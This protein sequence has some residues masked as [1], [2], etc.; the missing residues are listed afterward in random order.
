[1]GSAASIVS[2]A[3]FTSVDSSA[4]PSVAAASAG[5]PAVV[6][7]PGASPFYAS[8]SRHNQR[9][10]NDISRTPH[11]HS[12]SL[13][14]PRSPPPLPPPDSFAT[15]DAG[16][17]RLAEM[18]DV[19]QS[20]EARVHA[21]CA[22][23]RAQDGTDEPLVRIENEFSRAVARQIVQTRAALQ[24]R[25]W[26]WLDTLTRRYLNNEALS[27][28]EAGLAARTLPK[29]NA[30]YAA[31]RS[32]TPTDFDWT[33]ARTP[34]PRA[35]MC[36][37]DTVDYATS[38]GL[39]PSSVAI[40]N[41]VGCDDDVED[42]ASRW[43]SLRSRCFA[44]LGTKSERTPGIDLVSKVLYC[45]VEVM[46]C[47]V[48]VVLASLPAYYLVDLRDEFDRRGLIDATFRTSMI[49]EELA[50]HASGREIECEDLAGLGSSG[51]TSSS[52]S[53]SVPAY[54]AG[55]W[56]SAAAMWQWSVA[57]RSYERE[58]EVFQR[59]KVAL[60][61]AVKQKR[62]ADLAGA[63]AGAAAVAAAE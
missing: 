58:R 2:T 14:C 4:L 12:C 56:K 3:E 13:L 19:L 18:L 29:L 17:T 51:S 59:Q 48:S 26:D 35:V 49:R 61:I 47:P 6:M 16:L 54:E 50:H 34:P 39:V 53:P 32:L 30:A 44:P 55:A 24:A 41:R 45:R 23:E 63:F 25:S 57:V 33:K 11:T 37:L 31:L 9:I 15:A 1:M 21:W 20:A 7:A 62:D 10:A 43:A 46:P 22:E 40:R 52:S 60:A 36:V 27:S 42:D 28:M 38:G 8:H 5:T